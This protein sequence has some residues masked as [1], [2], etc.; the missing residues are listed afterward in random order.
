MSQR[1]LLDIKEGEK[2][3]VIGYRGGYGLKQK[4]EARGIR[5]G[6]EIAKISDSFIGGPVTIQVDNSKV[7]LGRGMAGRV[8][9][10]VIS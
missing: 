4:L 6:K 2:A 5:E 1:S 3:R 9:V 10:E 7:A 8:M